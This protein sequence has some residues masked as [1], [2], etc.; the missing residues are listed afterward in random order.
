MQSSQWSGGTANPEPMPIAIVGIGCRLPGGASSAEKFWDLLLKKQSARS[1]TPPD[2]FNVDGFYHPNGDKN[3]T[4]N[5]RGGHFIDEDMSAFDAPFFSISPAEALSMDPMQ[6]MLLEVVY[7]ATEN[8]GIPM[9]SLAGTDTGCYVGCFTNDWKQI[10]KKDPEQL[11]KYHSIGTGQSIL[12]NRISFCFDLQGPSMTLD[13]A[14]SSSLVA[15]HLACQG[16][17]TGECKAAIVGATNAVLLPDMMVGMSNLH[18]LSPDS[19]SYAF[20]ERANGYAR[21]EG[22]A[23][24]VLKPLDEALR[25]GDTVRAVIRGTAV[26]AN[27]SNSGITLPSRPGQARLIRSAY[28]QAGCD[29]AITGFFEAHGTGTPAGDPIEAGAIGDAMGAYRP[30]GEQGKLFVGSVKTN[31]GHLEGASGL[32]GLIKAV[33]SLEHGIIPPNLWYE[34]GNPAIDFDALRIRVPT[35]ASPWPFSGL[36]RASVNSFGY[37]GA[38]AHVIVDDAYHYMRERRLYGKHRTSVP[39]CTAQV[40]LESL[41]ASRPETPSTEPSEQSDRP[42]SPTSSEN[43][44]K[45][46]HSHTNVLAQR[47]RIFYLSGHEASAVRENAESLANH[48]SSEGSADEDGFLDDLS[49]TLCERRSRLYYGRAVVAAS[50][51]GLIDELKSLPTPTQRA[52]ETLRLGFIFNGQGAQWWAMGRELMRYPAYYQSLEACDKAIQCFGSSWSLIGELLKDQKS[53]RV[54]ES[55]LS[56]PL[57][58]ALQIAL[59]DLYASW[60]IFPARVVGHSSGEIAAAYATGALSLASAMRVAYFRGV[61]TPKIR[62]LKGAMMAAG[63]TYEQAFEELE[64][65]EDSHGKAVVACVNS[66]QSVTISGDLSAIVHLSRTL[67]SRGIFARRLQVE[68]AFHSHHMLA[69][70]EEYRQSLQGLDVVPWKNRKPVAMFSS[71]FAKVREVAEED[72]LSADYWVN[73]M[74]SCVRF[75][76][77]LAELC[78]KTAGGKAETIDILVELGPHAALAG[79]VKQ[80]IASLP[81][82]K[83]GTTP[84]PYMSTLARGQDAAVTAM[85][86]AALLFTS[87]YPTDLH[88]AN[89]PQVDVKSDLSVLTN[90]PKYSWNRTRRYWFESRFSSDYRFRPFPRTDILGAPAPDWNPLEPRWRNFIRLSEQPWIESHKIQGAIAYPAAG[91]CC[92]AIEAA[93][94]L[95]MLQGKQGDAAGDSEPIGEFRLRGIEISRALLVPQTDEGI[96]VVLSMRADPANPPMSSGGWHEFRIFSHTTS[97]GWAEHCHG[98]I[99]VVRQGMEDESKAY[100]KDGPTTLREAEKI[101]S[102]SI[103]CR[104]LYSGLDAV[105]LSYGPE[106]QGITQIS[107]APDQTVGTVRVTDTASGMPMGYECERLVHPATMDALLQMGISTLAQ[108]D[109]RN[110]TQPY[111]PTGIQELVVSAD[112]S[113]PIGAEFRIV[114]KGERYGFR[115]AQGHVDA[116][117]GNLRSAIRM[118]GIKYLA[119]ANS[120][121]DDDAEEETPRHC[122]SA[123]WDVDVDLLSKDKLHDILEATIDPATDFTWLEDREFLAYHFIDRVLAQVQDAEETGMQP[124]HQK[125]FRY[126]KHQRKLAQTNEHELQSQ[127]WLNLNEPHTIE[128]VSRVT[129]QLERAGPEGRMFLRMGQNLISILR[130]EIDPLA[131]MMEDNLLFDYYHF[132]PGSKGIYPKIER[133]LSILSHKYPD[134]EYLEIGAGTG[135]TTRPALQALGGFGSRTYP[136]FKTY[137]FTD[138]SSGFFEQSAAKFPEWTDKMEFIKLDIEQSPATQ[139]GFEDRRFDVILA[140]NVLHATYDMDRTIQHVRQLL[141]PGGKLILCELTHSVPSLSLVFGNLPGWW[142]CREPWRDLGPLLTQNQWDE[143]LK[144]NGFSTL[145]VCSADVPDAKWQQL[146]ILVATALEPPPKPEVDIVCSQT[147]IITPNSSATE[148]NVVQETVSRLVDTD[149][150]TSTCTLSES[151]SKDLSKT[152]IISFAELDEGLMANISPSDYAALQRL[153]K[154]AAGIVWVTRGGTTTKGTRPEMAVFQGLARTLRAENENAPCLTVD[155]DAEQPL[156]AHEAADLVLRV[157]NQRFVPREAPIL[158]TIDREF[159]EEDGLLRIKRAVENPKLNQLVAAKAKSIP[160]KA[161]FQDI[162]EIQRPLKVRNTGKI[163]SLVFDIDSAIQSKPCPDES[164][165]IQVHAAAINSRD[166]LACTDDVGN[167]LLGLECAGVVT[168]VGH[169]VRHLTLGDRVACWHLGSL[170]TVVRSPASH[171]QKIPDD[172]SFTTAAAIPLAYATALYSLCHVARISKGDSILIHGAAD[173]VGQAAIQIANAHHV[174]VFATVT[175]DGQKHALVERH[176]L[177]ESHVFLCRDPILTKAV[178][179]QTGGRGANIVLNSLTG[180]AAQTAWDVIAPFGR[181]I[182]AANTHDVL[183]RQREL[184]QSAKNVSY[185]T[186]DAVAILQQDQDLAAALFA[187]AMEFLTT[188]HVIEQSTRMI[189]PFS[190][191]RECMGLLR[192]GKV[193]DKIILEPRAGDL[194]PVVPQGLENVKFRS[195]GSYVLA[196]GLGGIGRAIARWMAKNGARNIIFISRRGASSSKAQGLL[197]NLQRDGVC[198]RVLTCDIAD[199]ENLACSLSDALTTLPPIRGVVNGA[200]ELRDQIFTNMPY[201]SFIS[202]L[203]PKVQGSWSLHQA[204]LKQPLDF[205]VMLTSGGSFFGSV[206]QGNYV[207]ACAYQVALVAHRRSLGLPATAYDV[208]KVVGIGYVAEDETGASGRNTNQMGMIDVNEEE[209]LTMLGLAMS[210]PADGDRGGDMPNGHLVTGIHSSNDPSKGVDWPFWSR[211][212][213]FSHMDFVRP[214]LHKAKNDADALVG[215]KQSLPELLSQ[216]S[217]L[218]EAECYVQEALLAKLAKSLMMPLEDLDA[219]R[220]VSAYGVDSLIAV[221]LRNWLSR[222]AATELPVF[223]ILAPGPLQGLVKKIVAKSTLVKV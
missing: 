189:E 133:Y 27:G 63:L 199:E 196:G 209:L 75:S 207:A 191:L 1:N 42:V 221:Q 38:N 92:M 163:D 13:T 54:N 161:E 23:A 108:G 193:E 71:S 165:E 41:Y 201:E 21:G 65:I 192:D 173:A 170:A 206:G 59:V 72:D 55:E 87:G 121:E 135:G 111:V 164:V 123:E 125:F 19:I 99:S 34:K 203:R 68:S 35:E 58:A 122:A 134:L 47:P 212:P 16:L 216:A 140:A 12:S 53:S 66:P 183:G 44:S 162:S 104:E 100:S 223:E 7:E 28:K 82:A 107:A 197:G 155:L 40:E 69:I 33:L 101:C 124:H 94:Q 117:D 3:G 102:T 25:D 169:A 210:V 132:A 9:S 52:S 103:P 187:K 83:A 182:N 208:G 129:S 36:R 179:Q 61:L 119:I 204:T 37:G 79:P 86:T 18:M 153:V 174:N 188:D 85:T 141:R 177:S 93:T 50:R 76:D 136:R 190:K 32:A 88:A 139:P 185:T 158:G 115:G 126:M 146:S 39:S 109:I 152:A 159:S 31:I 2:R 213:V 130:Q 77:A 168:R 127:D 67:T 175:S 128:R 180:E 147:L 149:L 138:V 137:A 73:N 195:D 118:T 219:K 20:D 80:I 78:T 116:L 62:H 157:F 214:H 45:S 56:Q 64:R 91:Y 215:Q 10:A 160:L 4:M 166:I 84:F 110:L 171:V 151:R 14:C 194:V 217:S 176:G 142:N 74:V 89:F 131:L 120:A 184:S 26:N 95:S 172:M 90:L 205:F 5:V 29:P 211:D 8:A 178:R 144:R 81:G 167:S 22:M 30:A 200:M 181:F 148:S 17:R 113:A 156:L 57:C 96:E 49:Y 46:L 114:A 51:Q 154:D 220:G 143:L 106:F 218:G 202:G 60:N 150:L 48:L 186:V 112:I 98:S 198:C 222:E 105:G 6:R 97:G 15:L 43:S 24:L 70:C 11:L 145:E